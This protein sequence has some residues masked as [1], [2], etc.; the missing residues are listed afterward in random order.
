[1]SCIGR[2]A[3]ELKRWPADAGYLKRSR[4]TSHIAS[5]AIRQDI[6]LW[7]VLAVAEDDRH[8]DDA[9][10]RRARRGR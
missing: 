2:G 8:L 7:P 10:S 6:L 5:A 9:R 4:G 3:R 1:M